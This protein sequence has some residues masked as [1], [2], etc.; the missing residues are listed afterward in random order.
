MQKT[1]KVRVA[2]TTLHPLVLKPV[3]KHKNYLVHDE[4]EQCVVGDVVMIEACP[5]VSK[6]KHFVVK[7]IVQPAAR[8]QD[9]TRIYSAHQ[10]TRVSSLQKSKTGWEMW[11]A[12]RK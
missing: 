4:T 9:D 2:K 3:T 12:S 10:D 11:L 1:A 8:V 5:R 7:D 6:R